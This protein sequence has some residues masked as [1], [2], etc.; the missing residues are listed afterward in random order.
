MFILIYYTSYRHVSFHMQRIVVYNIEICLYIE[1]D[2]ANCL[3]IVQVIV[4]CKVEY[5]DTSLS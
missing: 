1:I 3:Y 4:L 2:V 5:K